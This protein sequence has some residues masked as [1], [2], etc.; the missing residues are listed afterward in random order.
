MVKTLQ[1]GV[2][3]FW[4]KRP[5]CGTPEHGEDCLCDVVIPK[6]TPIGVSFPYDITFAKVICE[7]MG[8]EAP[9]TDEQVLEVMQMSARAKDMLDNP[10]AEMAWRDNS[11]VPHEAREFMREAAEMNIRNRDVI[12]AVK[13]H[14]GVTVSQ[15]YI[16]KRRYLYTGQLGSTK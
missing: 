3:P 5:G 13:E 14:W 1:V 9:Y 16:S 4:L 7:H 8:Y 11:K 6:P 10:R 12:A 2:L 15:A